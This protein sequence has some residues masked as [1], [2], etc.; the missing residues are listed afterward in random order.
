MLSWGAFWRLNMVLSSGLCRIFEV[1]N[2]F[3]L[4]LFYQEPCAYRLFISML[5]LFSKSYIGFESISHSSP[6]F[7]FRPKGAFSVI[8]IALI[9]SAF[10]YGILTILSC[11]AAPEG[12]T[13]WSEYTAKVSQLNGIEQIPAFYAVQS[14]MGT[15]GIILISIAVMCAVFTTFI[16]MLTASSRLYCSMAE[17]GILPA[18]FAKKE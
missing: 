2:S 1:L 12:M 15:T 10:I 13:N 4:H 5:R 9:T 16:S 17:D 14:S 8:I 11:C 6:E 7:K 3:S 18:W